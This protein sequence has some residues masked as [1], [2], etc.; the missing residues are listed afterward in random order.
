MTFAIGVDIGGTKIQFAAVAQDGTVLCRHQVP[1]E[2][3][4]GPAQL[5]DK[6]LA[7]IDRTR[8][9]MRQAGRPAGVGIGSAGQIDCRSGEVVYASDLLPGWAGTP[10]KRLVEA[11]FGLPVRIDND[12]N[13]VAVAEKV[14]G[15][16]RSCGSFVCIALGTGIGGAMVEGG[17]LVRGAF[18]GAGELGHVSVD[19]EG[20]LCSCGNN[21]CVE[22]YASG[23]GISRLGRDALAAA[24]D[25]GRPAPGW[26]PASR[27]IIA[28]W[29][30]GEPL[31]GQVM[32][33][34]LRALGAAIAGYIHMFNPEAVIVGGGVAEAGE[35]FF[36]ALETQV[37][38]RTSAA[39][40]DA[41]RLLPAYV[42]ADAG[43]IGAAAQIWH[44]GDDRE[45]ES[46]VGAV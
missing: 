33:R 19:F 23:S 34:A 20:P 7:G 31:A 13:V 37:R 42:G 14:Y 32:D 6:V 12:V 17:Q 35:P 26:E 1:T 29:L 3:S 46:A 9:E 5:M 41:C 4:R 30:A 24:R 25:E 40:R 11:R 10:V 2:A 27:D 8:E 43:V 22:L 18:G 45:D 44:Y 16:G 15:A 39:M 38:R 36:A 28:A 21:G